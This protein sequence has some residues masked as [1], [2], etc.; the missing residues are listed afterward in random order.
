M[1]LKMKNAL[2][3]AKA[4]YFNILEQDDIK[5]EECSNAQTEYFEAI[6]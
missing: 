2:D 5:P 1:T 3:D 6:A 4:K